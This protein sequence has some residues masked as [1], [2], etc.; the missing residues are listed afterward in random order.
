MKRALMVWGGWQGHEPE[1]SVQRFARYLRAQ[2]YDV[3]IADT[4]DAYLDAALM[5]TLDLIVP[6]WT[7]GTITKE[8]LA[9][10]LGAVER[11][12]G[13]AGWHG[14]MADRSATASSISSWSAG[15]GSR[16]PAT[17]STTR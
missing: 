12:V 5:G 10:L 15:S 16:T 17:S 2:D 7:M 6:V 13:I 3:T 1:Q 4:L 9:G 14:G 8:Q 11:G